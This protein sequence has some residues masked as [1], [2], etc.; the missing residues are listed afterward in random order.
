MLSGID[1]G[2]LQPY[3]FPQ[4]QSTLFGKSHLKLTFVAQVVVTGGAA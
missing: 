1:M 3:D 2:R 4:M